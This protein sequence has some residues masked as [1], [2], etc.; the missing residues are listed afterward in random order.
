M[1][2]A[3]SIMNRCYRDA[4]ARDVSKLHCCSTFAAENFYKALGFTSVAGT[5]V[6]LDSELSF[7][8]VLMLHNLP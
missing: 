8:A 6:L 5:S 2:V 7:P 1:G 3:R 4:S